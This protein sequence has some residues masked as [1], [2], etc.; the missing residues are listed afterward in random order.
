VER[1]GKGTGTHGKKAEGR[2][3]SAGEKAA[4]RKSPSYEAASL[5]PSD[6][7]PEKNN[8]GRFTLPF[9]RILSPRMRTTD[10]RHGDGS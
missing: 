1:T 7:G 2:E 9:G 4:G 3:N 6:Q 5:I 10:I 8:S